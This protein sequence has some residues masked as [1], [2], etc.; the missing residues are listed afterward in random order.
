MCVC[1]WLAPSSFRGGVTSVPFARP[2]WAR[3]FSSAPRT[4]LRFEPRVAAESSQQRQTLSL[5][6]LRAD[7]KFTTRPASEARVAFAR[8]LSLA[9]SL[10]RED[11]ST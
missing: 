1:V 2:A 5:G 4:A 8:A 11:K 6:A 10:A 3:F 9:F 7:L